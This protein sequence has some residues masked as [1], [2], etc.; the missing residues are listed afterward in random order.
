MIRSLLP[1]GRT[2]SCVYGVK[3]SD[4]DAPEVDTRG[5][6]ADGGGTCRLPLAGVVMGAGDFGGPGF[7]PAGG[8][9]VSA[10]AIAGNVDTPSPAETKAATNLRIRPAPLPRPYRPGAVPYGDAGP[11]PS[12]SDRPVSLEPFGTVN[13]VADDDNDS[14]GSSSCGPFGGGAD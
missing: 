8:P 7:T 13:L 9:D 5:G 14:G 12:T 2:K 4:L 3:T 1:S 10:R 11:G 6:A